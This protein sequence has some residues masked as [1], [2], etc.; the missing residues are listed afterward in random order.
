[1][2][3]DLHAPPVDVI[4]A[5]IG[6]RRA[7]QLLRHLELHDGESAGRLL[8]ALDGHD[9]WLAL[10]TALA[11]VQDVTIQQMWSATRDAARKAQA[12]IRSLD[13]WPPQSAQGRHAWIFAEA[14]LA[15]MLL[16]AH[17]PDQASRLRYYE[18]CARASF[19]GEEPG[20]HL[21]RTLFEEPTE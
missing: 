9:E 4:A 20:S 10:G 2:P 12:T 18:S 19:E 6:N 16:T 5:L 15:I 7:H 8:D 13:P 11:S 1:V 3:H 17:D 14:E 21:H